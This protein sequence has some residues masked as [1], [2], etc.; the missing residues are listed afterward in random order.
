MIF[1][2]ILP[3]SIKG[4][5]GSVATLSNWL[6]A[7]V[8]TMTANLLLTWSKGGISLLLS[9]LLPHPHFQISPRTPIH[10]IFTLV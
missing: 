10:V 7:F 2:Q 3:V 4:L 8:V 6:F 1:K 9:H 5:A